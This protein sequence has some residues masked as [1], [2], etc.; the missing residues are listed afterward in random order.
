MLDNNSFNIVTTLHNKSEGLQAYDQ[1]IADAEAAGSPDC[2]ALFQQFK[3]Q[4][5]QAVEELKRHVQML[6]QN[7]KF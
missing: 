5:Q 6:V 2:V 3:Q 7:G 1:Y 4:D